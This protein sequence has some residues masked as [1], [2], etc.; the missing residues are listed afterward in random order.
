MIKSKSVVLI[1]ASIA[2]ILMAGCHVYVQEDKTNT[3][4][5]RSPPPSSH[6]RHPGYAPPPPSHRII[7]PNPVHPRPAPL[8]VPPPSHG[9]NQYG[10]SIQP[11]PM[12]VPPPHSFPGPDVM[13]APLPIEPAPEV[14]PAP[15]PIEP[16]PEAAPAPLPVE[17]ELE[18]KKHPA[19]AHQDNSM[20]MAVI[21]H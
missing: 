19:P 4:Y 1:T 7:H 18:K 10:G 11:M 2:T 5:H 17:P 12:P 8:P 14:A 21:P 6:G 20:G 13:P 16:A 15:L 3:N 9:G